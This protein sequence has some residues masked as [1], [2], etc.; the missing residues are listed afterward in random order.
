M[1][2]GVALGIARRLR[3]HACDGEPAVRRDAQKTRSHLLSL[4]LLLA[5]GRVRRVLHPGAARD[6]SRSVGG[7]EIRV[8]R[9]F[10]FRVWSL[11][12]RVWSSEYKL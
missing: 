8:V 3:A 7:A 5:A 9:S 2:I 4:G 12:F 6:E 1:V 11:E 10:E